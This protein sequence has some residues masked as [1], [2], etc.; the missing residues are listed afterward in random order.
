MAVPA[1]LRV[2]LSWMQLWFA[3]R[4]LSGAAEMMLGGCPYVC[5]GHRECHHQAKSCRAEVFIYKSWKLWIFCVCCPSRTALS[6][7]QV[8]SSWEV[9][10]KAGTVPRAKPS[11]I[12]A[13]IFILTP[14]CYDCSLGDQTHVTCPAMRVGTVWLP[15]PC[16][17]KPACSASKAMVPVGAVHGVG[18]SWQ[19]T[20]MRAGWGHPCC[21]RSCGFCTAN[22]LQ[23]VG[24]SNK[25]VLPQSNYVLFSVCPCC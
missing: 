11:E 17:L 9:L 5:Q 19:R 22:T 4:S 14:L 20:V 15:H 10:G 3:G 6:P 12:A 23:P 21:W 2:F 18:D 7:H 13:F 1:G 24:C 25:C 16:P 8:V